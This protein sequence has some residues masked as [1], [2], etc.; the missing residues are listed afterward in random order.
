MCKKNEDII[1]DVKTVCYS[2]NILC[3]TILNLDG[4]IAKKIFKLIK[5]LTCREELYNKNAEAGNEALDLTRTKS[6]G[7]LNHPHMFIFKTLKAVEPS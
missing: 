3:I 1:E 4:F 7:W 5:C 2:V 6:S